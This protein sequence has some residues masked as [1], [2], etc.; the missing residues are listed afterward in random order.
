MNYIDIIIAV[1]VGLLTA[2]GLQKGLV[3]SL[4]GIIGFFLALVLSVALM[5]SLAE[6]MHSVFHIWKGVAYFLS[7]V[8]L[9]VSVVLICKTIASVIVKFFTIT[10]TRWVD[11]I[12]G[13]VFGFLIG[14]LLISAVF[15]LLSFFSF[16][17]R[18][19]P[20]TENSAL[21]PYAK[22]FFPAAYD[23]VVRVKPAARSFKDITGDILDGKTDDVLK[24]SEAGRELLKYWEELK[25]KGSELNKRFQD[26]IK[27]GLIVRENNLFKFG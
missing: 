10:S 14:S 24:R 25:E 15:V 16:T 20:E 4:M 3:K 23:L 18:L 21:Y 7:F 1:V 11:R 26:E 17:E 6:F 19:L 8:L 2:R 12:G 5:G 13:G 22:N 9:F 27:A